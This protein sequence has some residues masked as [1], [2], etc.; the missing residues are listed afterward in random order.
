MISP[1][2]SFSPRRSTAAFTLIEL[3]TVMAIIAILVSIFLPSM[4]ATRIAAN[5]AKTRAQFSQWGAAFESFRQEYGQYPQL[6]TAAAQKLVNQNASTAISGTHLFHDTL[7]GVRRDT[8]ALTGATTGT[9][10]PAIGQNLRRIRFINFTD[11]DFVL[12]RDV[13]DGLATGS[14]LNLIRDAFYN[15]SIAVVTDTNLDGVINGRDSSGGYPGVVVAGGTT[16]LR[17]SGTGTNTTYTGLTTA[18]T[19]GIHAGVIFYCAPPGATN[20]DV[21]LLMSWK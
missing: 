2:P 10:T 3:L 4:R 6:Y 1:S 11:S 21:D 15:T 7:A 9:P 20:V 19:G 18:T 16:T 5:R 17:P 13:T 12:Q 8:Q 14:Q